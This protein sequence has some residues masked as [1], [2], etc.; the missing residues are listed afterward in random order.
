MFVVVR[1]HAMLR[2]VVWRNDD[3]DP[4]TSQTTRKLHITQFPGPDPVASFH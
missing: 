3:A 1:G 2:G 4:Q